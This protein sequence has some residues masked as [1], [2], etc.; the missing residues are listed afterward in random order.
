MYRLFKINLPVKPRVFL[1]T[2]IYL[3]SI[4]EIYMGV[5]TNS[6][7]GKYAWAQH[8]L[9]MLLNHKTLK[10]TEVQVS[11]IQFSSRSRPQINVATDIDCFLSA[12]WSL[13][14]P[15]LCHWQGGS[16]THLILITVSKFV[17][18]ATS[19]LHHHQGS[20]PWQRFGHKALSVGFW[21]RAIQFWV[22]DTSPLCHFPQM[23]CNY[24]TFVF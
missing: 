19:S 5:N 7:L 1:Q 13:Q 10:G 2:L 15:N 18:K 6:T 20:Q 17:L 4:V 23:W 14:R 11:I 12:I 8:Y 16:V 24:I 9:N 21:P 22:Q 3:S